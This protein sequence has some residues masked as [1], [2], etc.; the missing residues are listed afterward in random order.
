MKALI[1]L[2][3]AVLLVGCGQQDAP[4]S[5]APEIAPVVLPEHNFVMRDGMKYGYPAAISEEARKAGQVA[6][7]LVM[8]L[9]AGEKDGKQQVHIIDGV[10]VSAFEC[11][12]PCQHI[13]VMSYIDNPYLKNQIKV[14]YIATRPDSLGYLMMQDALRGKLDQYGVG[15]EN[16][17]YTVWVDEKKGMQRTLVTKN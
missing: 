16:K 13:K 6:E 11:E 4:K 12:S 17:R 9:Y 7:T 15:D 1:A 5:A 8:V 3:A 10:S 14:E 2:M